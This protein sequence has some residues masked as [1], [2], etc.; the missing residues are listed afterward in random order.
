MIYVR[1][2]LPVGGFLSWRSGGLVGASYPGLQVA[3]ATIWAR[4]AMSRA[5]TAYSKSEGSSQVVR[6]ARAVRGDWAITRGPLGR[7]RDRAERTRREG[8]VPGGPG[9]TD[10]PALALGKPLLLLGG[11][12][13]S[14][15]WS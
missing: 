8:G 9:K 12:V 6:A 2:S 13:A 15:M 7:R 14:L 4:E 1:P 10:Q 5:S 3:V 11:L